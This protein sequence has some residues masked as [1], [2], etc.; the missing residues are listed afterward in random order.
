MTPSLRVNNFCLPNR[1]VPVR[2]GLWGRPYPPR[3]PS[4]QEGDDETEAEDPGART[5]QRGIS[6]ASTKSLERYT[7]GGERHKV[8][9]IE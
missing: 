6:T 3:A 4:F 1:L 9:S 8:Y 2:V 5:G 7:A